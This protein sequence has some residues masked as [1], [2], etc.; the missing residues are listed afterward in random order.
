MRDQFEAALSKIERM[1]NEFDFLDALDVSRAR[2]IV[3]RWGVQGKAIMADLLFEVPAPRNGLPALLNPKGLLKDQ[4]PPVPRLGRTCRVF[5]RMGG[6]PRGERVARREFG[7]RIPRG[8]QG[9]RGSDSKW[10]DPAGPRGTVPPPWT[11]CLY[12]RR[13]RCEK[14]RRGI[15]RRGP[16]HRDG[17]R[18]GI[19]KGTYA[20]AAQFNA[21]FQGEKGA[22][23][24]RTAKGADNA[25]PGFALERLPAPDRGYKL[26][27]PAGLISW[28]TADVQPTI[29]IGKSYVAVA[30]NPILAR[31]PLAAE[32]R[33]GDRWVPD[34]ELAKMLNGLPAK[35]QFLSV[36]NPCDSF[37]P[38]AIAGLPDRVAPFMGMFKG[39]AVGAPS[40]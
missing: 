27:S 23:G 36:G 32:S 26:I 19:R 8:N 17:R 29:L 28:I 31:A 37:W 21:Y 24:Q 40:F 13:P 12:L 11:N 39:N 5:D 1:N 22:D 18:G 9:A 14:R 7:V 16:S 38:E 20:L 4:L 35:L 15:G 6:S 3:V 30:N 33:P 34:G 2:R 25:Q 10:D